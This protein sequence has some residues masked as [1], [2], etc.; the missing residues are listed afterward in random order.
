M[1]FFHA[2]ISKEFSPGP[3]RNIRVSNY[4]VRPVGLRKAF[5]VLIR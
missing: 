2:A 1:D 3:W 5:N 4:S